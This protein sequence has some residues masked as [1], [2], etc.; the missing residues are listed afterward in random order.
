MPSKKVLPFVAAAG[1]RPS[2]RAGS[3]LPPR[4]QPGGRPRRRCC[5]SW[6]RCRVPCAAARC[7]TGRAAR[8]DE[9]STSR[10]SGA[11]TLRCRTRLAGTRSLGVARTWQA[12]RRSGSAHF[13][14]TRGTAIERLTRAATAPRRVPRASCRSATASIL[15]RDPGPLRR[16]S[17]ACS[18]GCKREPGSAR[19]PARSRLGAGRP[20][21]PRG[22]ARHAQDEGL[23][24]LPARRRGPI[25]RRC[26]SPG[27]SPTHHIVEATAPFFA[28][29]FAQM[30][31]AILTPERSVRWDGRAALRPRRP[32]RDAPP[33]DAA[34]QL[35]LTY[36]AS[37]FNPA[38]L[39]LAMMEKEMPRRYWKNLPEAVLIQPLAAAAAERS[40]RMVEQRADASRRACAGRPRRTPRQRRPARRLRGR[41]SPRSLAALARGHANAAARCPLGAHGDAG[42]ARRGAGATRR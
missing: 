13:A 40:G 24:A 11:A 18:G 3:A 19:R 37:I 20:H 27:S 41:C 32:P 12:R 36:Y 15:H 17:T 42:R 30:H 1:S 34:E 6:R 33:A 16:C 4:P 28:R 39:K 38:R 14:S 2:A 8:L 9:R 35:W 21:G 25:G 26:T 5:S 10:A 23:R 31:W 22:P 29:R 7:A